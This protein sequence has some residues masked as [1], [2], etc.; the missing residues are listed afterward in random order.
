MR[1]LPFR[2]ARQKKKKNVIQH[3]RK[4]N[5]MEMVW[6]FTAGEG[7][8]AKATTPAT[9]WL[10]HTHRCITTQCS[11]EIHCTLPSTFPFHA[12]GFAYLSMSGEKILEG[13]LQ[14]LKDFC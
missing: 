1:V 7:C 14:E 6:L 13:P 2:F 4:K 10:I 3:Q 8:D 12:E 5:S 9:K 11:Q